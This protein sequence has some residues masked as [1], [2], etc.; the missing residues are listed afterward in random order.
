L[1]GDI[2]PLVKAT[3]QRPGM[4]EVVYTRREDAL[5]AV[6]VYHNRQ[7]DG[8][9]MHCTLATSYDGRQENDAPVKMRYVSAA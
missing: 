6:D 3:L 2:G 1:F 8:L 5:R 4:A 7:L 9:P